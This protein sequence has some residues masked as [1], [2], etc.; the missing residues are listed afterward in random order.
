VIK[1]GIADGQKIASFAAVLSQ[2]RM[3]ADAIDSTKVACYYQEL[4]AIVLDEMLGSCI[5]ASKALAKGT[6]N[7]VRFHLEQLDDVHK[8]RDH[9]R[10]TDAESVASIK[11]RCYRPVIKEIQHIAR[12]R[13]QTV[14][15]IADPSAAADPIRIALDT[16][17]LM[18]QHI[19]R[20]LSEEN[21]GVYHTALRHLG[22]TLDHHERVAS[23]LIA[24][25]RT[26]ALQPAELEQL[27]TALR[28]LKFASTLH[29]HVSE[30]RAQTFAR[31]TKEIGG[32]I[33]I[34]HDDFFRQLSTLPFCK[35]ELHRLLSILFSLVTLGEVYAPG[36]AGELKSMQASFTAKCAP[37]R[38]RSVA[39]PKERI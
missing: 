27:E 25:L 5:K 31:Y 17:Q 35:E 13:L 8:L 29:E 9:T 4:V 26:E 34:V 28:Q 38:P 3:L 36:A 7:D 10:S 14:T 15:T 37:K 22:S 16:L 19:H 2:F 24:K 21:R 39:P 32:V 11:E 30:A 18:D 33:E 12:E 6:M 20:F 23:A 1:D